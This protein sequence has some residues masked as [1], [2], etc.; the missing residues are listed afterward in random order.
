MSKSK[1]SFLK[2]IGLYFIGSIS[3]KLL[4]VI[5]VPIYA[6]SVVASDLG[7]Y[8]YVITLSNILIP[9]CYVTIW[10]AILKFVLSCN[11]KEEREKIIASSASFMLIV[12]IFVFPILYYIMEHIFLPGVN[13]FLSTIVMIIYG[14]VVTWQY[15]CRAFEKNNVY[16]ISSIIGTFFNLLASIMLICVFKLGFDALC[17]SYIIGNLIII[18]IIELNIKVIPS[19]LKNK[20]DLSIIWKMLK[21]SLPL[22]LNCISAWLIMGFSKSIINKNLG[23]H[24]SG[25]Y[26]FANK[27]CVILTLFGSVINM[28]FIEEAIIDSKEEK[29]N[30]KFLKNVEIILIAFLQLLILVVPVIS[31]FY[32]VIQTT[33]YYDSKIYFPILL[34]YSLLSVMSTNIGTI[35][36][37]VNKTKYAFLTTMIGSIISISLSLLG[38]KTYGL[39]SVLF[40]QVIGMFS[41]NVLRYLF[42]CKYTTYRLNYLKIMLYFILYIFICYIS[43]KTSIIYNFVIFLIVFILLIYLNRKLLSSFLSKA[44]KRVSYHE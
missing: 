12:T 13:N 3:S 19:I 40:G 5:L 26:A 25:Q 28:A 8:D 20:I 14:F 24:V 36:Q 21:F 30:D 34:V 23:S 27:F 17:I 32:E 11:S 35:F 18:I 2:K 42:A 4:N 33:E 1:T 9:I 10:E 38:L 22:M 43:L 29:V 41:I 44:R 37:V 31:G 7:N 15:Y 6:F 16:V 39:L